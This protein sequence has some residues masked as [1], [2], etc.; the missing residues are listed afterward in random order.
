MAGREN[1]QL[2]AE[3]VGTPQAPEQQMDPLGTEAI[4]LRPAT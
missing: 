2:R 4:M 3:V 1:T